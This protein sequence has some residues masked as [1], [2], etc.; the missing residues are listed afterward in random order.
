MNTLDRWFNK[1]I[2]TFT[3]GYTSL[4][5]T[6]TSSHFC[7]PHQTLTLACGSCGHQYT[8]TLNCGDRLCELCSATTGLRIKK[9]YKESIKGMK[10]PKLL[11][12]TLPTTQTLTAQRVR[13][14]RASFSKLRRRKLIK[15]R[16]RGGLYSI[17]IKRSS[18]RWN[19]HLHGLIDSAYIPQQTISRL[20]A[21]IT[22]APIVDIRPAWSTSGG[23]NYVLKYIAKPPTIEGAT[24]QQTYRTSTKGIRMIQDFGSFFNCS[25]RVMFC[26]PECGCC[27]WIAI[28][29]LDILKF[30]AWDGQGPIP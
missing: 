27:E 13:F 6:E 9:R 8:A 11:T 14:L 30:E 19:V 4:V 25:V 24:N 12:L 15:N 23:L 29:Y 17:E 21:K 7:K 3:P 22:G 16:L 18:G 10:S 1:V 5:H 26:C 28:D 2:G 20:W